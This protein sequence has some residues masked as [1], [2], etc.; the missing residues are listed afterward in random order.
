[1]R[2]ILG[3]AAFATLFA[4]FAH[5]AAGGTIAGVVKD[6][7]GA[8]LRGAFVRA[9]NPKTRITVSVLSDQQGRYRI[10][11]LEPGAYDLRAVAID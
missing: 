5:G 7:A 3:A 10:Q 1:M 6:P 11:G 4:A 8:P 2:R 9:Q